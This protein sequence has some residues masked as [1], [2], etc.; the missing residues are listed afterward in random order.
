MHIRRSGRN[1]LSVPMGISA[2]I[3]VVLIVSLMFLSWKKIV[4]IPETPPIKIQNIFLQSENNNSTQLKTSAQPAT[5]PT[6][7]VA[8]KAP[9]T[10]TPRKSA[11]IAQRPA[12]VMISNPVTQV[13]VEK[14]HQRKL[15][16]FSPHTPVPLVTQS[17]RQVRPTHSQ[18]SPKPPALWPGKPLVQVATANVSPSSGHSFSIPS[19]RKEVIVRTVSREMNAPLL[20]TSPAQ[21]LT[22]VERWIPTPKAHPVQIASIPTDFIDENDQNWQTTASLK[23]VPAEREMDFSPENLEAIRKGFTSG[24]WGRIAKARYYPNRARKR[25]W[26]GKPIV[27]FMLA[28]NGDLLS[29]SIALASP[30]K[31]LDDAA[32]EAIKSARPFPKIPEALKLDS[33]RFKLPIS[34][35]LEEP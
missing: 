7:S 23:T 17:I 33:I 35:I 11:P 21:G 16:K 20:Q 10:P 4:P 29:S 22:T 3:H 28:R 24:V 1:L 14:H 27:E 19:P 2:G 25:G 30:Y 9:S 12:V 31:L 34:F 26:E 18:K 32:L 8:K 13:H 5:Q 15:I 6:H